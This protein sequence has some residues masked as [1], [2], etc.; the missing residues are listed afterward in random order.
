MKLNWLIRLI[1]SLVGI[2]VAA[3]VS[4]L[5]A[6]LRLAH[7][8][9]FL[10]PVF[11]AVWAFVFAPMKIPR[12]WYW[13]LIIWLVVS[14]TWLVW[15]YRRKTAPVNELTYRD[16]TTD[17]FKNARWRWKWSA[18]G[19]PADGEPYGIKAYCLQC[20]LEL[21]C[22]PV[23]RQNLHEMKQGIAPKTHFMC[24]EHGKVLATD[25]KTRLIES[26][27]V[28]IERNVRTGKWK[29]ILESQQ[30]KTVK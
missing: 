3:I 4:A 25:S 5:F 27:K 14:I 29:A 26:A 13:T 18:E 22:P 15:I 20:D 9:A 24:S 16:Y 21:V 10:E 2:V 11:T 8:Q 23:R 19:A 12:F 28:E 7:I 6:D 30:A 17:E 1:I